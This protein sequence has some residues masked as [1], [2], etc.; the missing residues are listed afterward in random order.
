MVMG[1]DQD[2]DYGQIKALLDKHKAKIKISLAVC[3]HCSL[4]AESCFM[5]MTHDKDPK[6]MP[7]YKFINSLGK[8]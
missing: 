6:Y 8:L 7:S 5:Y 1:S 4:C 3:A 2:F